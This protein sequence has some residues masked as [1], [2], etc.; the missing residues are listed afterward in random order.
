MATSPRS[1][2]KQ[3]GKKR[4][5]GT[6]P[7]AVQKVTTP[8]VPKKTTTTKTK[9][10]AS[11]RVTAKKSVSKAKAIKRSTVA[12]TK[13]GKKPAVSKTTR[14]TKQQIVKKPSYSQNA[15]A[16]V[17]MAA[18]I[19]APQ[20]S[21]LWKPKLG[22]Y[23]TELSLLGLFS[24][25]LRVEQVRK[26]AIVAA[27]LPVALLVSLSLPGLDTFSRTN[28]YYSIVLA[29]MILCSFTFRL[30]EP[31]GIQVLG[32]KLLVLLPLMVVIGEVMGSLGFSMLRHTYTFSGTPLPLV[33]GAIITFA[34]AEEFLFRGLIQTQAS[35]IFHPSVAVAL[36]ILAYGAVFIGHGS[37]LPALFAV[38]AGTI[39][40]LTYYFRQNLILTITTN[41]VMKLGYLG[42]LATFV[43]R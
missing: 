16:S 7:K 12:K 31:L 37:V 22:V 8:K 5:A 21:L 20:L 25:A 38:I 2:R 30:D 23:V 15:W 1:K 28:A 29:L 27:I 42:L 14:V 32:K 41:A 24:I 10:I 34:V 11:K 39:L 26:L 19:I 33:A 40:S 13:T 18:A 4:L 17:A 6:E 43:L 36:T 3:S 35:K 9:T